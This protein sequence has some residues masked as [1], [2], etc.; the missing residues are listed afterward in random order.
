MSLDAQKLSRMQV[1]MGTFIS[2]TL[3]EKDKEHFQPSFQ[4]LKN[5]E[6]KLSSYKEDSDIS[7]LNKH[8]FARLHPLT[9]EALA[10]SEKYYKETDGYFAIS[11]GSITKDLYAFGGNEKIPQLQ[12]LQD[13][14]VVM[15]G[16]R[17][18]RSEASIL[19]AM[20]L[21]LG[22]MG[23]GF[24][25]DKVST[26]LKTNDI[27]KFIIAAS[28]DIRCRGLCSI[29]VKHPFSD[30]ILLSFST[31]LQETGIST[32]GNYNRY[33]ESLAHNHLINPKQKKSQDSFASITLVSKLPSSDL[34]AYATAASVMP[35]DE[36]Y[37]FLDSLPLAYIV[38]QTNY[39]L[40]FSENISKFTKRLFIRYTEKK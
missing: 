10:L 19:P 5:V 14:V 9:Y 26:F 8:K 23:K 25:V 12:E 7:L 29:N 40:V 32:S 36:A 21:D 4:I 22:G 11:I 27:K 1:L 28:G 17:L 38:M 15:N 16:L 18:T 2:I 34:D 33:V 35:L 13:S 24:G 31:S 30:G 3:E 37:E 6:N 20:K 39:K